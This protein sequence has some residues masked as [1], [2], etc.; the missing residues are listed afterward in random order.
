MN[1]STIA[2]LTN[3]VTKLKQKAATQ[4]KDIKDLQRECELLKD[5]IEAER[6]GYQKQIRKLTA[7]I[8]AAPDMLE[9]L[10]Y[11]DVVEAHWNNCDMCGSALHPAGCDYY[12]A[13]EAKATDM[14]IAAIYKAEGGKP[15]K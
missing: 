3:R 1:E 9:A 11:R 14:R 6:E 7:L 4:R 2:A 8:A 10:R 5:K 12:Y 13:L 15:K